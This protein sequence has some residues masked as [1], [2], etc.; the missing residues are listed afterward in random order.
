MKKESTPPPPP[1]KPKRPSVIQLSDADGFLASSIVAITSI[2]SRTCAGQPV[3]PEIRVDYIVG[4]NAHVAY[5]KFED[6][7]AMQAVAAKAIAEWK[8]NT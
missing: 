5:I 6:H 2:P 4:D 3:P 8:L 1:P 7:I